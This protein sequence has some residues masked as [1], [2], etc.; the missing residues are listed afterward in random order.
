MG[1]PASGFESS[2]RNKYSDVVA[3]LDSKHKDCYRVFNLSALVLLPFSPS[4]PPP[5]LIILFFPGCSCPISENSYPPTS[6]H[7][8]ISRYPH[9]DHHPPPLPLLHAATQEMEAYLNATPSMAAEVPSSQSVGKNV[10]VIHCKASPAAFWLLEQTRVKLTS[11]VALLVFRCSFQAGKG[12]TGTLACC[13]MERLGGVDAVLKEHGLLNGRVH[14][15]GSPEDELDGE[16][17]EGG[18]L[19]GPSPTPI[20]PSPSEEPKV[21]SKPPLDDTLIKKT[22]KKSKSTGP[23]ASPPHPAAAAFAFH[24]SRRMH[25][26]V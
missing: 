25:N 22:H 5:P 21:V 7:G 9:P 3:F 13:L 16:E 10:V 26:P 2:Y 6:F 24:T 11:R 4:R 18:S 14:V 1:Y 12:R 17:S 19:T 8:R 23:P 15:P 20:A